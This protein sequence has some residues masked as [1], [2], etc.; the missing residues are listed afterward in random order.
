MRD[1][2][3]AHMRC[4]ANG[5]VVQLTATIRPRAKKAFEVRLDI[6]AAPF[7]HGGSL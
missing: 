2:V 5:R 7:E 1:R 4:V 3:A 6:S